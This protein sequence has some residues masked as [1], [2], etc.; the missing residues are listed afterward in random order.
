[1]NDNGL[2]CMGQHPELS[3]VLPSYRTRQQDPRSLASIPICQQ[4]S[5]EN[6]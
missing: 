1:M 3:K 6:G 2:T 4:R 5:P